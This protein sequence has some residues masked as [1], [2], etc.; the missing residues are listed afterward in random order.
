MS[1]QLIRETRERLK[2]TLNCKESKVAPGVIFLVTN[3][4]VIIV[5]S[6]NNHKRAVN[7]LNRYVS[8]EKYPTVKRHIHFCGK[9]PERK[10]W[11]SP[12]TYSTDEDIS[13]LQETPPQLE[14]KD[15]CI[16]N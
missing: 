1:K 7:T 10:P 2:Y 8:S 4:H 11:I 3:T 14:M 9:E 15:M 6:W 16:V 13:I 12:I 5:D